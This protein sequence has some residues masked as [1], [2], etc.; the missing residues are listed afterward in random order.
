[1][2]RQ[3]DER[4]QMQHWQALLDSAGE[5]I[6]GLDLDGR[7]TFVNQMAS[8]LFGFTSDELLGQ[9]MHALV[10]HTREDGSPYPDELC[11]VYD[12]LRKNEPF[13][14]RHDTLFRKDRTP[15]VAEISA[16]PVSV[17]GEVVGV[18]VTFRDITEMRE[19]EA[20]LHE[21]YERAAERT[22]E[23]DAVI[24]SMPHAVYVATRD[25]RM[26]TNRRARDL[27][28]ASFPQELGTLDAAMRGKA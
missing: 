13:H 23:L 9:N 16:Q 19:Q 22:A 27:S 24:E 6:W 14:Q 2:A 25:G 12:V 28:G 10:H 7:C 26:R 18:V 4:Q 8:R 3:L 1:M 11:P 17:E 5:G 15:F 21:A 20:A